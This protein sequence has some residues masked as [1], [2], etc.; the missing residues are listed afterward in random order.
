MFSNK[1]MIGIGAIAVM[2]V[3]TA[4]EKEDAAKLAAQ[5]QLALLSLV[6]FRQKISMKSPLTAMKP[7]QVA[8]TAVTITN[9]SNENWPSGGAYPVHL[10]YH[11]IDQSQ[12]VVVWDGERTV[13]PKDLN[14]GDSINVQ[15]SI[16]APDQPGEY[17]LRMTMLQ[18]LVAWFDDKGAKPLT[19]PVTIK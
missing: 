3:M 18:E 12:N 14:A 6:D 2:L 16:K 19:Q 13:L 4:C 17:V 9:T 15:A 1:M 5:K 11:W 8:T 7:G 10:A